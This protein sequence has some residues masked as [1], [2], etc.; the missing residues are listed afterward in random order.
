[1]DGNRDDAERCLELAASALQS[2]DIAKATRLLEKSR[3]MYPLPDQQSRLEA[4]LRLHSA[5]SSKPPPAPKSPPKPIPNNDN[6]PPPP[7]KPTEAMLSSVRTVR[8]AAGKS[9]YEVLGVARDADDAVL[10]RAYRKLALRLHPD[11]N[12]APGADEAFKRVSSAFVTLSDPARRAHYDQFGTD[13]EMQTGPMRKYGVRRRR[14][15]GSGGHAGFEDFVHMR[16]DMSADELF[17]FLF[18]AAAT[19]DPQFRTGRAE[20]EEEEGEEEGVTL[21]DRCRPIFL[22]L[23]VVVVALMVSQEDGPAKF[24]LQRTGYH[25]VARRTQNDVT[26]FISRN[27]RF[28]TSR[29][30]RQFERTVDISAY[31]VYSGNCEDEVDRETKLLQNSRRW[32]IGKKERERYREMYEKFEKPW[33]NRAVELRRQLQ[34]QTA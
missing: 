24:S 14:G 2:N 32:L 23:V 22:V 12:H 25:N 31:Q 8:K 15:R 29:E 13:D 9:H 30:V 1:M 33:C 10:K 16:N 27:L 21:W 34:R 3:R 20:E 26:Y 5:T 19:S 18:Q 11:R 6:P 7:H 17:E 4:A 28:G